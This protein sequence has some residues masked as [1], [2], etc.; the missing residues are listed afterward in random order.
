MLAMEKGY[1][2]KFQSVC[3]VLFSESWWQC[4]EK[5]RHPEVMLASDPP[6]S[7]ETQSHTWKFSEQL[8]GVKELR[9]GCTPW[10]VPH[11][12]KKKLGKL[13]GSK[14]EHRS[15]KLT[16][17]GSCIFPFQLIIPFSSYSLSTCV[18]NEIR[19]LKKEHHSL[20]NMDLSPT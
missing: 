2:G 20:Y 1:T 3:V 5:G 19:S 16:Q 11:K 10:Q 4:G 17:E 12:K 14:T 15:P 8:S 13:F 7:E 6:V 9:K 18:I